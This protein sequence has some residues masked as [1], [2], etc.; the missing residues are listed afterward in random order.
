MLGLE[1]WA[2]RWGGM[3]GR[4]RRG[5]EGQPVGAGG[6]SRAGRTGA[7]QRQGAGESLQ[8][9]VW[10]TCQSRASKKAA[11]PTL[12][13]AGPGSRVRP[14]G[15]RGLWTQ[16]VF[17]PSWRE[18]WGL[19]DVTRG[20]ASSP[21]VPSEQGVCKSP[22]G[23]CV[24]SIPPP[25]PPPPAGACLPLTR[26]ASD[27]RGDA[28]DVRVQQKGGPGAEGRIYWGEIAPQQPSA[29][30]ADS[31]VH[32]S[33]APASPISPAHLSEGHTGVRLSGIGGART[34]RCCLGCSGRP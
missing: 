27:S 2:G 31:P 20:A 22:L 34:C 28:Q 7:C 33:R 16:M 13:G 30:E 21:L 12:A 23:P 1:G 14:G 3:G 5:Q 11:D 4:L 8:G 18:A 29:S 15:V 17:L 25:S 10:V 19:S 9:W 6:G 24:T 26:W 32:K